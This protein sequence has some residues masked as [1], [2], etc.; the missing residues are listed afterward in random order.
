MPRTQL[1]AM[2]AGVCVESVF[3]PWSLIR[4]DSHA[5]AEQTE[6]YQRRADVI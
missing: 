3:L 6:S 2:R 4:R 5:I 1:D